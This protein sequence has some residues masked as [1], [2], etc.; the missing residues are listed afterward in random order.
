MKVQLAT[1]GT[2]I[3]V[4]KSGFQH[5][6][7]DELYLFADP[8]D[9]PEISKLKL[10]FLD[11]L[12][13]IKINVIQISKFDIIKS[14]EIIIETY[15]LI[16]KTYREFKNLKIT[17]NMTGGTKIMTSSMLLA[18]H[19]A[20]EEIF[21][22]KKAREDENDYGEKIDIPTTK[23]QINEINAQRKKLILALAKNNSLSLT[24][25]AKYT[26]YRGPQ[27]IARYIDEFENKN[28]ITIDREGTERLVQLTPGG[29][30]LLYLLED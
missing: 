10:E 19:M 8:I 4:I 2:S 23:I 26:G 20:S 6:P 14:L 27:S 9:T 21:Y 22:I 1:L 3:E 25:L 15:K 17:M 7:F 29:K 16:K 28:L 30:I 24:Q 12:P 5:S 13:H 11:F 18:A